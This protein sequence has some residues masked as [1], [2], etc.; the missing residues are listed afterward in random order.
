VYLDRLLLN[1]NTGVALFALFTAPFVAQTTRCLPCHIEIGLI[2]V[3]LMSR[4]STFGVKDLDLY[5]TLKSRTAF[6]LHNSFV[7]PNVQHSEV[8]P[9]ILFHARLELPLLRQDQTKH[10]PTFYIESS[11]LRE[12]HIL[13]LAGLQ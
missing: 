1:S 3:V 4:V 12:S 7:D 2:L 11:I 8:S 10:H 13:G 9:V 5:S 6:I